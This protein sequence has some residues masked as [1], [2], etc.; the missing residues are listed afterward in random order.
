MVMKRFISLT[1]VF[2]LCVLGAI[3][4]FA[5][6]IDETETVLSVESDSVTYYEDGSYSTITIY[7]TGSRSTTKYGSK[8]YSYHSSAGAL[9]WTVQVNGVFIYNGETSTCISANHNVTVYDSAWSITMQ[10]SYTSNDTAVAVATLQKVV[11]G[12]V[13]ASKTG[14]VRLTCDANGNL[15]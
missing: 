9:L 1:L 13:Q 3:N 4:S 11:L 14:T 12:V 10:N 5:A 7:E 8:V 15:S 6:G 2:L